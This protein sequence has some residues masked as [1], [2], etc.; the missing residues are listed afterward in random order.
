[1]IDYHDHIGDK[2]KVVDKEGDV[3]EGTIISYDVG[4]EDDL[5]YDSIG[6]QPTGETGYYIGVPIP[7]IVDFKVLEA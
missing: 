7:D 1:M 4:L 5:D 3:F 2:V 6:I